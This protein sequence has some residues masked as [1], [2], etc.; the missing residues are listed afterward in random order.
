ME[1]V[2]ILAVL[3]FIVFVGYSIIKWVIGMFRKLFK[4]EE[5]KKGIDFDKLNWNTFLKNEAKFEYQNHQVKRASC[6]DKVTL[7]YIL[8]NV[9]DVDKKDISKM[10]I[11][12]KDRSREIKNS[13]IEETESIWNYDLFST[14]I[15]QHEDGSWGFRQGQN[16]V[17]IIGYKP[18]HLVTAE[19]HDQSILCYDNSIIIFLR[20]L[21]ADGSTWYARASVMI[22]NFN[23]DD[24]DLKT[25]FSKNAPQVT[26]FVMAFDAESPEEKLQKFENIRLSLEEKIKNKEE[27]NED[28]DILLSGITYDKSLGYNFGYGKYLFEHNRYTD[29]LI[30]LLKVYEHLKMRYYESDNETKEIFFE[31]CYYIGY[32]FNELEKYDKA[33]FYLDIARISDKPKHKIEYI[34]SLVNSSDMRALQIVSNEIDEIREK[35]EELNEEEI[36]YYRFLYRRLAYLYIEY[37]MYDSAKE[38]LEQMK[39]NELDRNFAL[40][41]LRYLDRLEKQGN[42]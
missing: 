13:I 25:Q 21:I 33:F 30:P 20:G 4:K 17:L 2:I 26:T 39:E 14:I 24:D 41:E 15:L 6:E 7:G 16:T 37:K 9:L 11:V 1:F 8:E 19:E 36:I 5:E 35:K 29:A 34:N 12:L 32:C 28:E 27:L 18:S 38:L 31:S 10:C 40:E 3:V 22:P 42:C 23:H